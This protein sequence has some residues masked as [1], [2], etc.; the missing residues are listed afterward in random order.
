MG[1]TGLTLS[2]NINSYVQVEVSTANELQ[3]FAISVTVYLLSITGGTIFHYRH[4]PNAAGGTL[5]GGVTDVILWFNST[6]T[7]LEVYGPNNSSIGKFEKEFQFPSDTWETVVLSYDISKGEMKVITKDGK[8]L[9]KV[10]LSVTKPQIG[11]PAS[12]RVGAPFG[13]FSHQALHGHVIC[14]VMHDTKLGHGDIS[15][16]VT[17]CPSDRLS[18]VTTSSAGGKHTVLVGIF[19]V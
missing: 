1:Y 2:G 15:G 3:D 4:D 9:E 13:G 12:L 16:I 6:T 19:K 7:V 8:D 5:G 10:K 18:E 11:L 17:E 14:L